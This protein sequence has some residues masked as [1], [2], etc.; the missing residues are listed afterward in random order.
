[1]IWLC[2]FVDIGEVDVLLLYVFIEVES[3]GFV[4]VPSIEF[5][6]LVIGLDD[7]FADLFGRYVVLVVAATPLV[8]VLL[9][10]LLL[11]LLGLLT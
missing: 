11:P 4:D 2:V 8:L 10:L 5:L 1:M 9:L 3:K 7:T 6:G